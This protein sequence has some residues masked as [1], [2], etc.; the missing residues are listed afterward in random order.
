VAEGVWSEVAIDSDVHASVLG[1]GL[2]DVVGPVVGQAAAAVAVQRHIRRV[3]PPP[4][5]SV[6]SAVDFGACDPA[7]LEVSAVTPVVTADIQQYQQ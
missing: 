2:E 1:D 4:G 5:D 6:I 7:W 3:A